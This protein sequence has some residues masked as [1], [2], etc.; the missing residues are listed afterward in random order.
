MRRVATRIFLTF[1]VAL[2]AFGAVAVFGI[3]R[4]HDARRDLR[5]LSSGYLPL[6]RIA[7]QLETKDWVATRALEA[8]ALDRAARQ[9]YLPVARAHFPALV[10]EKI[11]EAKGVI[12][13]ARRLSRADDARFLDDVSGRLDAL[14][15][16]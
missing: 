12:A 11:E 14:S 7:A 8:R 15:A 6:T 2:A 5:L 3:V 1:A 9:A 13:Q 10:K 4:L 16:R